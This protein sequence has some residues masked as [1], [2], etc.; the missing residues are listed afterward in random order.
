MHKTLSRLE[1]GLV[2][3]ATLLS[4]IFILPVFSGE[5]IA[6]LSDYTFPVV[7]FLTAAVIAARAHTRRG[8]ERLAGYVVAYGFG[9]YAVGS[10][11]FSYYQQTVGEPPYPG[12]NDLF[13]LQF[14]PAILVAL[15]IYP[16]ASA[17]RLHR[18]QMLLDGLIGSV[19]AGTILGVL[20]GTRALSGSTPFEDLISAVNWAYVLVD[21]A[22]LVALMNLS[23][24]HSE[25]TRRFLWLSAAVVAFLAADIGYAMA[26]I[27]DT[28]VSGE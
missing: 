4:L 2:G 22:L 9:S 28:Y 20:Y 21:I 27:N 11:I 13:W 1:Y 12:P 16:V 6:K 26:I 24:R 5:F 25:V 15:F 23:V 7:G 19:A 18:V 14:G 17:G 8:R 3:L 10:T